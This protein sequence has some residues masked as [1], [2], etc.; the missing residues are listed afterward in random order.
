MSSEVQRRRCVECVCACEGAAKS[1]RRI[2]IGL[3]RF[4]GTT[5]SPIKSSII[6]GWPY[7][8][9]GSLEAPAI[10]HA[11]LQYKRLTDVAVYQKLK[12][13]ETVESGCI[14]LPARRAQLEAATGGGS[15]SASAGHPTWVKDDQ[16]WRTAP[17]TTSKAAAPA[18]LPTLAF[19]PSTSVAGHP[20]IW[21]TSSR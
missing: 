3:R 17:A 18:P 5:A 21:K 8:H 13:L 15:A 7:E 2:W 9:S 12:A 20:A 16:S 1:Q 19:Q 11:Y 4:Y 10:S 14:P 6:R